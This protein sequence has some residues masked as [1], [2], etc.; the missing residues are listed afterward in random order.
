MTEQTITT[1]TASLPPAPPATEPSGPVVPASPPMQGGPTLLSRSAYSVGLTALLSW[2]AGEVGS[3][4]RLSV[5]FLAG[6]MGLLALVLLADHLTG[7]VGA[8]WHREKI[9]ATPQLVMMGKAAE[10]VAEAEVKK[11]LASKGIDL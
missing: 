6:W 1:S 9:N 10:V 5:P 2:G 11:L 7:I 8:S 4:W 3:T